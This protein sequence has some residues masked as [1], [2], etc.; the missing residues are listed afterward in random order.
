MQ[1]QNFFVAARVG[2]R[3]A[4]GFLALSVS[5]VAPLAK[6]QT[7]G[8][9]P[10]PTD[11][12]LVAKRPISVADVIQMTQ[13]VEDSAGRIAWFSPDGSQ[14]VLV[15]KRGNLERN[16]ND[17]DLLRYRTADALHSAESEVLLTMSSSSNG[18]AIKDVKW[19]RDNRTIVFLG[20]C[21]DELSQ[22]Y[23]FD[24]KEKRLHAVTRSAIAVEGYDISADGHEIVYITKPGRETPRLKRETENAVIV[25]EGETLGELLNDN[26]DQSA[27]WS[28]GEQLSVQQVD[29]ATRTV[30]VDDYIP[31]WG[32]PPRIAP[33]G[34][35]A[36]I[37]VIVRKIPPAWHEYQDA[38]LQRI[39]ASHRPEGRPAFFVERYLLLDTISGA[40]TPLLDSPM[41]G[42]RPVRWSADSQSVRLKGVFL[43]LDTGDEKERAKRTRERYNVKVEVATGEVHLLPDQTWHAEEAEYPALHVTVKQSMTLRPKIYAEDEQGNSRMRLDPNPW[44]DALAFGEVEIIEWQATDGHK[45]KGELYK[46]PDYT[47]GKRYPLVIQT[48]GFAPNRFWM[49]GPWSSAFS[50]RP[51]AANGILVLQLDYDRSVEVTAGEGRR[52]MA[53]FAGAI[54]ELDRR[55][56]IDR[57]RVGISGFSRTVY[58]TEY[59]LTHSNCLFAAANLVDGMDAGYLQYLAFGPSESPSLNDGK[60]FGYGLAAWMANSPSFQLG[61][62]RT[63][64]RMQSHGLSGAILSFWEWFALL[65][66]MQ[67]PVELAYIPDAPHIIVKPQDKRVAQEGLVDW[68]RFWLKGEVDPNPEKHA[69]YVRWGKLF[70]RSRYPDYT[71]DCF[72]GVIS[73]SHSG[74]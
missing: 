31:A 1:R 25:S 55:G 48:H 74:K 41:I 28:G 73:G 21:P 22:V 39:I 24:T 52:E 57:H 4:L 38:D 60:P 13:V 51:L 11:A 43:P 44:L 71:A 17:F 72:P 59:A 68:F 45:V 20:E 16:T 66:D 49:D 40:I 67:R 32:P 65:S 70:E 26:R 56:L 30:S 69:Q 29:H 47:P 50:A 19:M 63:P 2:W 58:H 37:G 27:L 53:S 64:V 10:S 23:A 36:V 42:F 15:L 18:D 12:A 46:P 62:M 3:G 35:H 8:S 7:R 54:D 34:K 9:S 61:R 14:F 6:P 33:D 5:L